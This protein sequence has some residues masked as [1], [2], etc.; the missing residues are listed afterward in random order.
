MMFQPNPS[1]KPRPRS[2]P[3][4]AVS[5]APS[6][7]LLT[8][9]GQLSLK[10]S[11]IEFSSDANGFIRQ[12]LCTDK[13][14]FAAPIGFNGDPVA[15]AAKVVEIP[16]IRDLFKVSEVTLL[17]FEAF[18]LPGLGW[19][20]AASQVLHV[21]GREKPVRARGGFIQLYIKTDGTVYMIQST[22][23][24]GTLSAEL[25][26][27]EAKLTALQAKAVETALEAVEARA[28]D[29]TINVEFVASLWNGQFDPCFRVQL[30]KKGANSFNREFLVKVA[31][32]T[33]QIV[34]EFD[35]R[36]MQAEAGTSSM[37]FHTV[38][39]FDSPAAAQMRKHLLSALPNPGRLANGWVIMKIWN[40]LG[41]VDV[42]PNADGNYEF[43]IDTAEF[44][45]VNVFAWLTLQFEANAEQG[46]RRPDKPIAVFIDDPD[47]RDNAYDDKDGTGV[48]HD[49]EIHMGIGTGGNFG[50]A[51]H[52][53]Y[54][55]GVPAHEGGHQ[56]VAWNA[57]NRNLYGDEGGAAHEGFAGDA[58]ALATEA[59]FLLNFGHEYGITFNREWLQQNRK[60]FC[61]IG[62]YVKFP[63]GI[64]NQLNKATYPKD[65][66]GEVHAD[67]LIIGGAWS[68]LLFAM[69][70]ADGADIATELANFRKLRI[71]VIQHMP[72]HT[73]LFRDILVAAKAVDQVEFGGK[74][75]ALIEKAHADHGIR[76]STVI[77]D[78]NA[79]AH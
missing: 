21:A 18:E 26:M 44:S 79:F 25:S 66:E 41:W 10:V 71:R 67:G 56:E 54:D 5:R 19:Q 78:P 33:P 49:G 8:L 24:H 37:I 61:T 7:E 48:E 58:V 64:R 55:G 57:P 16:E 39:K 63:K 42:K 3:V 59:W 14:G 72:Q 4:P 1:L 74:Y 62:K 31:G 38:P 75:W 22:L 70:T 27:D 30:I 51:K 9:I 6:G 76:L 77:V 34:N 32:G 13:N 15:H 69:L 46:A 47:V 2:K 60:F 50:L 36:L 23:R 11:G 53:S 29:C 65:M 52:E 40:G 73:V 28:A 35:H 45:A 12:L 17:Q 20:V 68:D 43:A